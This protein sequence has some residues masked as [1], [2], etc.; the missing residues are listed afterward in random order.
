LI[1]LDDD[2]INITSSSLRTAL[3]LSASDRRWIDFITQEVNDTWDEK[4]PG[5][6]NHMGYRG[7]EEFIRL[8]FEEYLLSMISCVKYHNYLAQHANNPKMALPHVEGDPS[9]D[10]G[11]EWVEYWTK[12]ENFRIWNAHTDSLLFDIV[13]PKH[14]CA[15]GLTVDD[16][17]RR[18]Q[19]Q[20]QDLHLDERFA[21]GREV[22]G[23]N[24]AAAREKAS[25]MFNKFYADMEAMREAQRKRAEEA[26]A[27]AAASGEASPKPN[28]N[29]ANADAAKAQQTMNS[30]GAKAGAYIGSWAA[31]AGEKRKQGWGSKTGSGNGGGG[32]GFG[33]KKTKGT[34]SGSNT[35]RS[36]S[37]RLS[38]SSWAPTEKSTLVGFRGSMDTR[39]DDRPTTQHSFSE[40]V[41]DGADSETSSSPPSPEKSKRPFS[42]VSTNSKVENTA[43]PKG[44]NDIVADKPTV[45]ESS[46]DLSS[47]ETLPPVVT[48]VRGSSAAEVEAL[49]VAET[50]DSSAPKVETLEVEEKQGSKASEVETPEVVEVRDTP[51]SEIV[52]PVVVEKQ[53]SSAVEAP[54]VEVEGVVVA[55][56]QSSLPVEV[57]TPV[58]TE[59]QSALEAELPAT[60]EEQSMPQIE[61][62]VFTEAQSTPKA[63][64]E[65]VGEA[66]DWSVEDVV[67]EEPQSAPEVENVVAAE[68]SEVA[69]P[70]TGETAEIE[71]TATTDEEVPSAPQEKAF[72]MVEN[73]KFTDITESQAL[74]IPDTQNQSAASEVPNAPIAAAAKEQPAVNNQSSTPEIKSPVTQD[75]PKNS[76]AEAA[77]PA[78]EHVQ[79]QS[80]V[81]VASEVVAEAQKVQSPAPAEVAN[82]VAVAEAQPTD[83]QATPSVTAEAPA[84]VAVEAQ[85]LPADAEPKSPVKTE[86]KEV[87]ASTA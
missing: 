71:A 27:A 22:L 5:R 57:D 82:A 44:V 43:A 33:G 86:S 65:V 77:A 34:D 60:V 7:S 23:R 6:P 38:S 32:W 10:F 36:G 48:E 11:T 17:Q 84:D 39:N 75:A 24:A 25:T 42:P 37:P 68:V 73:D 52:A 12:T 74:L 4:N 14:P 72:S 41:L 55:E 51:A 64:N 59:M 31:W 45:S 9:T 87:P 28:A 18:I 81:A 61:G 40:S 20:V 21:A 29:A 30:V 54:V 16:V 8:Q 49:A 47:S 83:A 19:Q 67:V 3:A 79:E 56:T 58:V 53:E 26:K 80:N 46:Q 13:E 63:E 85:K 66:Q 35:P 1:N 76:A 69:V 70:V 62:S 78:V 50:Q 15:G 2:T